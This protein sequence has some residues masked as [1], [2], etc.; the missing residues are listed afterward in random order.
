MLY[1]YFSGGK[2][3]KAVIKNWINSSSL[4]HFEATKS[5]KLTAA[6]V[7]LKNDQLASSFTNNSSH[8]FL[9][10]IFLYTL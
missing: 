5:T 9:S 6:F 2:E 7:I 4:L 1:F 8:S 3:K 10:K